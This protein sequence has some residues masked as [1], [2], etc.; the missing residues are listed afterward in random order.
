M[1]T[2]EQAWVRL[3][4]AQRERLKWSFE[5]MNTDYI[6]IPGS[7]LVLGVHLDKAYHLEI[8]VK[9]GDYAIARKLDGTT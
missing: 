8:V 6:L 4:T 3:K 2:V 1:L 7:D 9:D 5:A